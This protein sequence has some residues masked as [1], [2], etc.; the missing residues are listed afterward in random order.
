MVAK[1][2]CKRGAVVRELRAQSRG[3]ED[4]QAKLLREAGQLIEDEHASYLEMCERYQELRDALRLSKRLHPQAHWDHH[5]ALK[6][7]FVL[8][9]PVPATTEEI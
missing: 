8:A 6:Q 7:A 5:L 3:A 1:C 4:Y 2:G 9:H